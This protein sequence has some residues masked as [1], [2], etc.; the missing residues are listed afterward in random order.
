MMQQGRPSGRH[1]ALSKGRS[2]RP[3]GAAMVAVV[4]LATTLVVTTPGWA[5]STPAAV[6][7]AVPT[8]PVEAGDEATAMHLAWKNRRPVE[9]LDERTES[10]E[11]FALP[12]GTL[13]TRQHASPIRVRRGT[14]WAAVNTELIASNGVVAP[15]ATTLDVRF[16]AGGAAPLVTVVRGGKSLALS[17]PS[18]LPVPTLLGDTAKYAEVLPGV[19]LLVE[20]A[21]TKFRQDNPGIDVRLE[22]PW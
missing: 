20:G 6:S 16:S 8:V 18:A 13:R 14:G 21:V 2:N 7:T 5:A 17:W 19:D 10:A 9:I 11:T 15:R 3:F 22:I 12:D 4:S 1:F